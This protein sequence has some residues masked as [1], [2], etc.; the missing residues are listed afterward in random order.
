MALSIYA[1][2]TIVLFSYIAY[3]LIIFGGVLNRKTKRVEVQ[4]VKG[5]IPVAFIAIT[6]VLFIAIYSFVQI[7]M[8]PFNTVTAYFQILLLA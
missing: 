3:G 2:N 1:G 5:F 7:F 4:K 8:S 6:G